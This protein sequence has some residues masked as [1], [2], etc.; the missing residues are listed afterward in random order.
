MSGS[1]DGEGIP[2][3]VLGPGGVVVAE[4]LFQFLEHRLGEAL[5]ERAAV[6]D[7]E[8]VDLGLVLREVVAEGLD[9]AG[10]FRPSRRRRSPARALRRGCRCRGSARFPA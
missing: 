5:F 10:G 2:E 3:A 9:E 8:R 1:G 4:F 6:E 7:L